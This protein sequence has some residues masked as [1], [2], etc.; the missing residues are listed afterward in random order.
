MDET[1]FLTEE[2]ISEIFKCSQDPIYWIENYCWIEIKETG[3][4]IQFKPFDYQK[5]VLLTLHNKNNLLALKSRRVGIS[6]ILAAY[7]AW[8]ANFKRGI[9]I[10]FISINE[11]KAKKLL[12]KSRFILKNLAHHDHT[13]IRSATSA[14]WM[15]N[16]IAVDN[17]QL[18]AMGWTDDDGDVVSLSEIASLTTTTESGRGDAATFLFMDEFAFLPNQEELMRSAR[19]T[20][21]RGGQW[22]AASCQTSDAFVYTDRGIEQLEDFI[23]RKSNVGSFTEMPNVNVYGQNGFTNCSL[24]YNNGYCDT[25]KITTDLNYSIE[26]SLE[27]PIL[28]N[29]DGEIKWCRSENLRIGD[30]T[31]INRNNYCFGKKV[32][33]HPYLLGLI[34]GDGY[35]YYKNNS[36]TITITSNDEQT[37]TYLEDNYGFNRQKDLIHTCKG[38]K[39]IVL[40]FES[41][42]YKFTTAREK[43]IP[44][45]VLMS[46]R[47]SQREVLR[48]LFDADGCATKTGYVSLVSTSEKLIDQV[49]MMLLNFGITSAKYNKVSK[50]TKKVRAESEQWVLEIGMDSD[51]FF[52]EIGFSLT[53]KQERSIFVKTTSYQ[54]IIP[55]GAL[56]ADKIA[57]IP[58]KWSDIKYRRKRSL[59]KNRLRQ[60][61]L[62]KDHKP[63]SYRT[64]RKFLEYW[65]TDSI[66]KS[67]YQTLQNLVN[68]NYR[69]VRI[70]S[71]EESFAETW[72]FS[73]NTDH[74]YISNGLISHQTPNGVGDAFHSLCMS[75]ERGENETY[76]FLKIHWS[77]ADITEDMI[78]Q[79]TEGLTQESVMQEM[80]M[81]FLSSGDPVFN[82]VDLAA[83]YKPFDD[84][85]EVADEVKKYNERVKRE[86]AYYFS[87]VDTAVG[88]LN[89]KSSKRDYHSFTALT[90][91]GIQAGSYHTKK[92]SLQ[93][94]AGVTE[95]THRKEIVYKEGIVSALHRKYPG[96]MQ[97][98]DNGPGAMVIANHKDPDD[99]ISISIP[100]NT[101]IKTKS[102]II[103]QLIL[104]VESHSIIITDKFT[105]Q[106]M[107]VYQ[108]G[109]VPGQFSAPNG[110]YYDDPVIS[111]ALAYDALLKHAV[112]EYPTW[113]EDLTKVR[114]I[115]KDTDL[116]FLS[117][118]VFIGG[119]ELKTIT[120][121]PLRASSAYEEKFPIYHS[122]GDLDISRIKQPEGF[123]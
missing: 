59:L 53:R 105:Y 109:S 66:N 94:W 60:K 35:I 123:K 98:E 26:C 55:Y 18:L 10:L 101:N 61:A 86:E 27:H 102:Q 97:I 1:L 41:I 63:I 72:D 83:C 118:T 62:K 48:G 28:I 106:C 114:L 57:D 49:R 23:D 5:K 39:D 43:E 3:E 30:W 92:H 121:T 11:D 24:T 16:N 71:I 96:F 14:A 8:L 120:N 73:M 34:L 75:A 13:D 81:E 31:P 36:Y 15:L 52:D 110:D 9:N 51:I 68:K 99:S 103:Q 76:E 38:D 40:Y 22:V 20:A 87:G 90:A 119:P 78:R 115:E 85:P 113:G 70:K 79:A 111:L 117:E 4:I 89:K 19:M 12:A 44:K 17:Q 122:A 91:S 32:I 107:Q 95:T 2:Q 45:D 74:S 84:Y 100:F 80:E 42:G 54:D 77:E 33:D 64:A 37:H 69:W 56:L 116:S 21:L 104:A 67:E 108:R 58:K 7:A 50:P 65:K 112:M 82:S 47:E 88:K 29:R 25:L 93:D 6:W 46:T